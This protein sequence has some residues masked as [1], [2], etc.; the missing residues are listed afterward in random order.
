METPKQDPLYILRDLEQVK[1][2]ADPL[3]VRILDCFA[4]E[5]RTTKQV[6]EL[7]DEKPTRLYHHVDALERVGLIRLTQTRQNRGHSHGGTRADARGITIPGG[8]SSQTR[9]IGEVLRIQFTIQ[10]HQCSHR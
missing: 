9:E 7:I 6:A 8:F 2:I 3:R 5:P 10:I 1:V 4:S